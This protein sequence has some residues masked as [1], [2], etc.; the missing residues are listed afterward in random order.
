[1][2]QM[3]NSEVEHLTISS[4]RIIEQNYTRNAR[5]SVPKRMPSHNPEIVNCEPLY[6]LGD[7][8]PDTFNW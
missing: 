6:W 2:G 1:M 7:L 4:G 8:P 5:N 3:G